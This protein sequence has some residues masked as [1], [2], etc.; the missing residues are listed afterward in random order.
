M[1]LPECAVCK[2]PKKPIGRDAGIAVDSYCH[3][4]RDGH[5]CPGYFQKPAPVFDWPGELT[6]E[7]SA[8]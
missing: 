4:Y 3:N 8:T 6:P 5:G 1:K 7:R 2:R